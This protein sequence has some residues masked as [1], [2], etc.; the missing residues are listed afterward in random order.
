M[1][2]VVYIFLC[3]F[4]VKEDIASKFERLLLNVLTAFLQLPLLMKRL[5]A[6]MEGLVQS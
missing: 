2:F 3:P 5:S 6:C 4:K 1:Y